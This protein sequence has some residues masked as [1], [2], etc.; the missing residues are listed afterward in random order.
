MPEIVLLMVAVVPFYTIAAAAD[1]YGDDDDD[2]A[3][4]FSLFLCLLPA[5][6]PNTHS[7]CHYYRSPSYYSGARSSLASCPGKYVSRSNT[8]TTITTTTA[9][10][11]T[12]ATTTTPITTILSRGCYR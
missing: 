3:G 2:D 9:T 7:F 1:G 6:G 10:T 8:A 4:T 5:Q 12:I 11:T